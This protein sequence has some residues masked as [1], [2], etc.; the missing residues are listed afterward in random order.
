[1]KKLFYYSIALLAA[2][3]CAKEIVPQ[4]NVETPKGDLKTFTIGACID[5]S[6]IAPQDLTKANLD[7]ETLEVLWQSKDTIGLVT[8]DGAITPAWLAEGYGGKTEGVFNY[9]AEAEIAPVYAYY[10]YTSSSNVCQQTVEGGKLNITLESNQPRP[11]NGLINKNVLIMVAKADGESVVFKNTCAIAKISVKGNPVETR[12][13]YVQTPEAALNG[14]GTVDM[15][16]DSPVFVTNP[17]DELTAATN[18]ISERCSFIDIDAKGT[19]I[20]PDEE[21]QLAGYLV[22]PA[23]TYHSLS[24]EGLATEGTNTQ[25][26]QSYS[27]VKDI[28]MNVGK[29]RPLNITIDVPAEFTDLSAGGKYANCYMIQNETGENFG[30]GLYTRAYQD[31]VGTNTALTINGAYNATVLW[32]STPGLI[33]SVTYH[34]ANRMIYFKRDIQKTGNA[35]ITLRNREGQVIYSWHIWVVGETVGTNTFNSLTDGVAPS[36]FMDRNI[37]ATTKTGATATGL[38][39]Q[40]GRKDPFPSADPSNY[41][42][43]TNQNSVAVYPDVIKTHVAQDGVSAEWV[44]HHPNVYV[45]GSAGSSGAED[46]LKGQGSN[47]WGDGA[48]AIKTVNDPCPYGYVVPRKKDFEGT[49]WWNNMLGITTYVAK[50]GITCKDSNEEDSYFPMSGQWRRTNATTQMANAGTYVYLWT[51]TES[52]T[53]LNGDYYGTYQAQANISSNKVTRR[54]ANAQPR[55]WGSNVRCVKFTE[56]DATAATE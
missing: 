13:L 41:A 18:K 44:K 49:D 10:P 1:M 51:C 33:S 12:H 15:T 4:D 56:V 48:D 36:V 19:K 28:T 5:N 32:Q 23:G 20:T 16:S 8:A 26:I 39:Y 27:P 29:I 2:V 35:V 17:I 46:W 34:R 31:G 22:M 42:S 7:A 54:V 11:N 40:Y 9:Q 52:T 24:F 6:T 53:A 43:G 55:R 21:Y 14:A 47:L 25:Y 50:Q 45:W 30:F 37:G 3:S 38:H